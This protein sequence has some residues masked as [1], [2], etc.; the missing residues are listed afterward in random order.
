MTKIGNKL[1]TDLYYKSTDIHHCLYGQSC[2]RNMY[3]GSIAYKQVER[4]KRICSIEE[5][6]NNRLEQLKQWLVK[7]G[8]RENNIYSKK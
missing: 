3:E 4:F 1:K 5:K 7:C 6:L 2:H 8:Y